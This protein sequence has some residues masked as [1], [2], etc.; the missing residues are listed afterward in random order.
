[1][2]FD[3]LRRVRKDRQY[4]DLVQI[5]LDLQLQQNRSFWGTKWDTLGGTFKR[6]KGNRKTEE[7]YR[8]HQRARLVHPTTEKSKN[9]RCGTHD[10]A[11]VQKGSI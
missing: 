5:D 3:T 6:A 11:P 8:Q 7:L 10:R 9:G 4:R 1:M 2:E